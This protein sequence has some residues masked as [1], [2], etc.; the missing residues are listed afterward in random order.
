MDIR[1]DGFGM[2]LHILMRML[3]RM[4]RD[5]AIRMD[6]FI[7]HIILVSFFMTGTPLTAY[8]LNPM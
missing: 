2:A 6:M 5:M 7:Q 1:Q 3:M 4:L 8:Y